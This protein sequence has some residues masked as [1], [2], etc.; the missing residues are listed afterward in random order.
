MQNHYNLLYLE[1]EREMVPTLKVKHSGPSQC[2]QSL[3]AVALYSSTL[4]SVRPRGL[5]LPAVLSRTLSESALFAPITTSGR[6][7]FN[8][9]EKASLTLPA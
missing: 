8:A 7:P 3:S 5:R 9:I 2:T 6:Y 4:A 1:E